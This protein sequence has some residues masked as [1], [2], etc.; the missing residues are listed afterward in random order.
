MHRLHKMENVS[1]ETFGC[2][3]RKMGIKGNFKNAFLAL[4]LTFLI[5]LSLPLP[6]VAQ[7]NIG[8]EVKELIKDYY[9][10]VPAAGVLQADS[11]DEII[12]A[13]DDPYSEYFTAQEY[14]EFVESLDQEFSG[15]GIY[16][17]LVADGVQVVSV[18]KGSPAEAGGIKSGDII[19]AAGEKNLTGLADEEAISALH[20]PAGSVVELTVKRG[21]SRFSVRVT[22]QQ[23]NVPTVTGEIIKGHTG[24]IDISTFGINTGAEF[25]KVLDNLSKQGADNWI[26][27]LR[28]NPGGYLDSACQVA[29]YFIGDRP[30]IK[31][32]SRD[33]W[34]DVPAVKPERT[35]D[36]PVILLINENSASASE[37]VAAAVKD[38][39]K[40]VLVGTTT[41]GKGTVQKLFELSNGDI[42]KMTVARFYSPGQHEINQ[43]GVAPDIGMVEN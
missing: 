19:V 11:A 1:R 18:I 10:D 8:L 40:G 30:V 27:D 7:D 23:I 36:K 33:V 39:N 15:V 31:M 21:E 42:L 32:Q 14:Q 6:V 20:G 22:R 43:V 25:G 13:L 12:T 28:D 34:I 2:E 24:Y 3:S 35:I 26:I 5:G 4:I 29:G 38:Y 37:V 16:I 41:Y 17:E 9:V